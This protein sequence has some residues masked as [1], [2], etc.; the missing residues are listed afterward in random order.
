MRKSETIEL[1]SQ[2]DSLYW[3]STQEFEEFS[4]ELVHKVKEELSKHNNA[5]LTTISFEARSYSEYG[6]TY[7]YETIE[8]DFERDMTQEE[9]D[10]LTE[11]ALKINEVL[12]EFL[13]EAGIIL[14][15]FKVEFGKDKNGE[16]I[17]GDEISPDGCRLWDS[18]T[19]DMLDKELFRKGKD[20]EVMDAYVEVYNRIIPD[21]EKIEL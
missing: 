4:K 1:Y 8:L 3:E 19:L 5:T 13:L 15:D 14:V 7:E 6:D 16:I 12:S 20:N 17:L 21:D 18:E 9:I 11:K 2:G 10:E